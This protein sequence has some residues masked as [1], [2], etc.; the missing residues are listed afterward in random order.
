[1]AEIRKTGEFLL[2]R[3][4]NV[5][6]LSLWPFLIRAFYGDYGLLFWVLK[7][8]QEFA[9][10]SMKRNSLGLELFSESFQSGFFKVHGMFEPYV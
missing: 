9:S 4:S 3:T 10:K 5:I 7:Q 2:L 6:F 8:I 1:M